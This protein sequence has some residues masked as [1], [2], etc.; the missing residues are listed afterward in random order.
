MYAAE[1]A[2][3]GRGSDQTFGAVIDQLGTAAAIELTV[4]IGFYSLI[5]MSLN[6]LGWD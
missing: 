5:S 3:D 6:G 1:L 2:T 4:L